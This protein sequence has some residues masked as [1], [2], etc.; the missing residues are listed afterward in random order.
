MALVE[1]HA[2][3]ARDLGVDPRVV[4][5]EEAHAR[6]SPREQLVETGGFA[7]EALPAAV[8]IEA[9]PGGCVVGEDDV[10]VRRLAQRL[11]LVARVVPLG[12]AL[13]LELGYSSRRESRKSS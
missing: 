11:D 5:P 10:E 13:Q 3:H 12:V 6:P 4:M 2:W 8:A 7:H 9:H 1:A